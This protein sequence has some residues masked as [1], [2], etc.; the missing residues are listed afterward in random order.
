MQTQLLKSLGKTGLLETG[1]L[2]AALLVFGSC[3]GVVHAHPRN[4][5]PLEALQQGDKAALRQLINQGADMNS[6]DAEGTPLLMHAVLYSDAESVRMLLEHGADP[7]ATNAA[8]ATALI[9]AAGDPVKASM[10]IKAGADVN[11]RSALGR[12]PLLIAASVD[13]AG[14]VA[15]RL[16]AHG[17]D[18][19]AH[20]NLKGNPK[21][22]SGG[23]SAPA[24]VEAA[25]ARDGETLKLLLEKHRHDLNFDIDAT[26]A[27]GGTALSEAVIQGNHD[28]LLRLLGSRAS[29][30]VEVTTERY[31]PLILAAMRNDAFAIA[32][33]IDAGADVNAA[34]KTGTTVLMWAAYSSDQGPSV[35]VDTLLRAGADVTAKNRGGENA[36][37]LAAWHG[38]THTYYRLAQYMSAEKK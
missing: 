3:M 16:L 29:V 1:M 19:S 4:I 8:G 26:D 25:K 2:T 11:A 30:N 28:N 12:T 18:D 33:L 17:A 7:N 37:A 5:T 23:G 35:A 34:D 31:T 32:L 10:L 24:I 6:K 36:L 22:V 20:D 21:L 14:T 13:G 9:W 27:N 15:H 38:K